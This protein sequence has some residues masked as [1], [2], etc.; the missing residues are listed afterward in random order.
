MLE[1][2]SLF[3]SQRRPEHCSTGLQHALI[4]ALYEDVNGPVACK[5]LRA[6]KVKPPNIVPD[7]GLLAST[8]CL[9]VR[10]PYWVHDRRAPLRRFFRASRVLPKSWSSKS[11][12]SQVQHCRVMVARPP[13]LNMQHAAVP[14]LST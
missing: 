9:P 14:F 4:T 6:L 10:V 7:D 8:L 13:T 5:V 3:L 12:R 11:G 2:Q 1:N